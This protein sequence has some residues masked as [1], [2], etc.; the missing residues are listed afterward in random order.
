MTGSG[1]FDKFGGY[2]RLGLTENLL[3]S[4]D[5][6]RCFYLDSMEQDAMH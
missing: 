3:G 5:D 1:G 6:T 4:Q 2:N